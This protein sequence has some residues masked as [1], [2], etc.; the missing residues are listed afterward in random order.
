MCARHRSKDEDQDDEDGPGRNGIA[1]QGDCHVAAREAFSHD[2][3]ANHGGEKEERA[4]SLGCQSAR[5]VRHQSV[6]AALFVAPS[7]RPMSR[8]LFRSVIRSSERIGSAAKT[9]IRLASMR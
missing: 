8:S 5:Q 1:E 9:S 6:S 4:K 2:A 3:R 7:M